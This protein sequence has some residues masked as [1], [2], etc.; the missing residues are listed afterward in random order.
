MNLATHKTKVIYSDNYL[1]ALNDEL[2]NSKVLLVTSDSFKRRG[3]VKNVIEHCGDAHFIVFDKV[4][5]NPELTDLQHWINELKSGSITQVVALGGGSVIDTAK[6][7]AYMLANLDVEL[8][9]SLQQS[10]IAK[11]PS[12]PLI[13][14]PTTSGTGSEVTPFATVWDSAAQKKFSLA[15]VAPTVAILDAHLTLSLPRQET[16]YPALDALSHA[17]ESLWNKNRTVQSQ[18]HAIQA[19]EGICEALPQILENAQNL[20]ARK[21]LQQAATLAG[22]AISHT[23]TAIAH[24][25]SY[26]LTIKYG[27][28]HGLA[29]SFTLVAIMHELGYEKLNLSIDLVDTILE[30][31][32]GLDLDKEIVKFIDWQTLVEQF[33][34]NLD[35][36]RADNFVIPIN[37]DWLIGIINKSQQSKTIGELHEA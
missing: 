7:M 5:P 19:I 3:I 21:T 33:D 8:K 28:P 11:T 10:S 31:L 37:S 16:L 32:V 14:I 36:S 9:T 22:L 18:E 4:T 25:I 2:A 26:P 30:L 1:V 13:A 34:P 20:T 12:L 17:L 23:K 29:C 27:M 15:N 35:P 6:V 24:A